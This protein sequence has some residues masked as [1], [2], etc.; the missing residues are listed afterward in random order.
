M[1]TLAITLRLGLS[2]FLIISNPWINGIIQ[3]I[4]QG[5]PFK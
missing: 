3:L 2:Y 1:T 4:T 5:G